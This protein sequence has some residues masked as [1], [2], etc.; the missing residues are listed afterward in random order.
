[1]ALTL[2]TGNTVGGMTIFRP[3]ERAQSCRSFSM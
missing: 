1:M 3:L 2:F